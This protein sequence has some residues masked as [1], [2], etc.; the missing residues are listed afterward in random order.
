MNFNVNP[1]KGAC[2]KCDKNPLA[3]IHAYN[4]AC[5]DICA[6]FSGTSD[7]YMGDPVCQ[8]TCDDFI[9]KKREEMFGVGY[10]DHQQPYRPVLWNDVPAYFVS[11][12]KN[13][14]KPDD[15]LKDSIML[16]K[17]FSPNKFSECE[18]KQ[19]MLYNSVE[20]YGKLPKN[21]SFSFS[22]VEPIRPENAQGNIQPK[23]EEQSTGVWILLL[24]TLI[25]LGFGGFF[26]YNRKNSKK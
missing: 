25:V 15:A 8:K 24:I 26:L 14:K 6:S 9:N 7:P 19:K 18:E 16:C 20:E 5:F 1:V 10:C 2:S 3:G 17:E 21:V 23:D 22:A 11:E 12:I 13:G 4:N